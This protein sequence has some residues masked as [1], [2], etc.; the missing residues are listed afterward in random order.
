MVKICQ[1]PLLTLPLLFSLS[2]AAKGDANFDRSLE[3]YTRWWATGVVRLMPIS[4]DELIHQ[5]STFQEPPYVDTLTNCLLGIKN[6]FSLSM[7]TPD[8]SCGGYVS[9]HLPQHFSLILLY[10]FL[11]PSL[12]SYPLMWWGL[13]MK[14]LFMPCH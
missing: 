2:L 13:C 5:K 3:H 14:I 4:K 10:S 7:C 9:L 11:S 1:Q 6:E 12:T 8:V